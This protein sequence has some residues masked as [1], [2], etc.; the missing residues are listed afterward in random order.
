MNDRTNNVFL[1]GKYLYLKALD[2]SDINNSNWF[3]W[4]NDEETT[5]FMQQH[6]YPNT[7]QQQLEFWEKNIKNATDKIQLGICDVKGGPIVGCVSLSCIDYL[8]RRAEIATIIGEKEY[9]KIKYFYESNKLILEHGFYSLNLHRI[10]GG[11]IVKELAE[12]M[13]RFFGFH[14]EGVAREAVFKN[15]VYHDAYSIGVL[16]SEFTAKFRAQTKGE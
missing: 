12:M 7:K 5:L 14:M 13:G 8:N 3:D 2:E 1:K 4:F 16:R 9:R 11:T 15:G 6:Y 10:Y